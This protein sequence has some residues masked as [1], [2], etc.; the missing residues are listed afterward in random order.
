MVPKALAF[1]S[2]PAG[3]MGCRWVPFVCQPPKPFFPCEMITAAK[4]PPEVAAV[5]VASP[6]VKT[7]MSPSV[8]RANE[9]AVGAM[10][11]SQAGVWFARLLGLETTWGRF[12][13]GGV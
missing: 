8:Q 10:A 4:A 2:V 9:E 12:P 11:K 3:G 6:R 1:S 7:A 13:A 5:V